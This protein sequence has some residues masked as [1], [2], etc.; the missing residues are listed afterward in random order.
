[1]SKTAA[2]PI[3]VRVCSV[4]L[5]PKQQRYPFLSECAVFSCVQN[6][7]ATHSCRCVQCFPVSKTAALPIPVGVCSVFLCPKQ[8]RYPFLAE[9][10]VFS[11]VQNSSATHSCQSVQC[12]PVSKT[13]ALPIPVRVCSVFLCPKQQRYPFLSVCAVFSCVQNSS[14]THSC[15]CVQCFPVSKTAALPIPVRVC[16]VF[17]CPKQQRYPFLSVCAVFSCV[18]NSSAT[19]SCRCVQC[20]PVSKTAAL[21]IPVRVCSVF[22]C[23]KQQRYPFL[24]VC[25]VFSCVQ[26]SSATHSCQS[27]QCFPVSK[28]AALPIPVR[29]CSVFLCPKQQRY[30]FLSECAVFSC[31]Q[32]S[33]ATHSCRCVQ[34]F[35]V[36][37]TAA[38]PIPV[39]VCSV[40]LC[41]KQQRYPFLSVCAVFSCV[42]NSS[43]TH[44]CWCVQCFPVSKTA[45]LPIPVGV[46]SVFLCPNNGTAASL[47]DF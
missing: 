35:P 47:R 4:F 18:Q 40:F 5:C 24:S 11:C 29:V 9:C 45:A 2:L 12:F 39:G 1:M 10:A 37:K 28:T 15:R 38:L 27:V 14:A 42:Q 22:L 7:S 43:A 36:S 3:P 16:S 44:S 19:H 33:S 46:C 20:F 31:V 21:P 30:P 13:A 26:N 17:L 23:P 8:Q 25:A 34:C 41:P 32:N 6:S